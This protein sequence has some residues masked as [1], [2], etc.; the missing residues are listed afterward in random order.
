LRAPEGFAVERTA[1]YRDCLSWS[2]ATAVGAYANIFIRP[3]NGY[4][5]GVRTEAERVAGSVRVFGEPDAHVAAIE[6]I[7]RLISVIKP[8]RRLIVPSFTT[9]RIL[10]VIRLAVVPEAEEIVVW[11]RGGIWARLMCLRDRGSRR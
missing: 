2:A 3:V 7:F 1:R 6:Y 10:A 8:Y 4:R 9:K 11:V 5:I